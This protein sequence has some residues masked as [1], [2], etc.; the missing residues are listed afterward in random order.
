MNWFNEMQK[1]ATNAVTAAKVLAES[2]SF[3]AA[4]NYQKQVQIL[5]R[6]KLDDKRADLLKTAEKRAAKIEKRLAKEAKRLEKRLAKLEE[7]KSAALTNTTG[8][9][10]A[11]GGGDFEALVTATSL[12]LKND[13]K[14]AF[15]QHG[16]RLSDYDTSDS[17]IEEA[18]QRAES[19]MQNVFPHGLP[20]AMKESLAALS[21]VFTQVK[22]WQRDE[23]YAV[24][25]IALLP[26]AAEI[27]AAKGLAKSFGVPANVVRILPPDLGQAVRSVI[28]NFLVTT[29]KAAAGEAEVQ[30]QE[31]ARPEIHS[32]D[33]IETVAPVSEDVVEAAAVAETLVVETPA[34]EPAVDLTALA[35]DEIPNTVFGQA[36]KKF[37]AGNKDLASSQSHARKRK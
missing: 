9:V 30:L 21:H 13:A 34:T 27:A 18:L 31:T 36:L 35:E 33:D 24:P 10:N 37:K 19:E 8:S 28:A 14:A 11:L 25:D 7:I 20:V 22:L 4:E 5:A 2:E 6:A 3:N 1:A 17:S 15:E 12:R 26:E 23:Q 32:I 29:A 16:Q